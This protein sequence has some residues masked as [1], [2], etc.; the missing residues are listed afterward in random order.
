MAFCGDGSFIMNPQI[1]IDAAAHRAR[2][3][4]ILFDNRRMAAISALQNAQYGIDYATS[5]SVAVDYVAMANSVEGV[6]ALH[7]GYSP[8]EFRAALAKAAEHR[9][10]S[11]VHVP[12]YYGDHELGGLGVYGDWNVGNWCERVQREHHRIGL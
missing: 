12:V 2:G 10:L 8:G 6:L 7:G 5:D 4:I 3:C 11:L 1:L 9:G